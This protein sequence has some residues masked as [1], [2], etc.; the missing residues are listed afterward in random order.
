MGDTTSV[1]GVHT[2]YRMQEHAYTEDEEG[3]V[4]MTLYILDYHNVV[5]IVCV[6]LFLHGHEWKNRP[7]T[8]WSQ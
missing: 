8:L 5:E 4:N 7:M 2:T 6:A 3:G 1:L